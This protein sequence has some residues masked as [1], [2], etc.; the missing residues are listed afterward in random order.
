MNTLIDFID[1]GLL[2]VLQFLQL[3]EIKLIQMQFGEGGSV[4]RLGSKPGCEKAGIEVEYLL[5]TAPEEE[6]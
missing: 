6:K 2:V 1:Q 3:A 5:V 4:L